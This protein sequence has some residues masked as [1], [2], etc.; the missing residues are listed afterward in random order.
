M[1]RLSLVLITVPLSVCACA[2]I[3]EASELPV[4]LL[5]PAKDK[6]PLEFSGELELAGLVAFAQ[7][8]SVTSK[9]EV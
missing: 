3:F 8:H 2:D 5:F 7:E 6:L 1:R 4:V 9:D